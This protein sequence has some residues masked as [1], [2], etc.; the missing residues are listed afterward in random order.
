MKT[1]WFTFSFQQPSGFLGSV[2]NAFSIPYLILA[3]LF[4]FSF[5]FAGTTEAVH[6]TVYIHVKPKTDTLYY[7]PTE[8]DSV[9]PMSK[10][11]NYTR[12]P[13]YLHLDFIS[14]IASFATSAPVIN[15]SLEKS[16][17]KK[18]SLMLLTS[19]IKLT[20]SENGHGNSFSDYYYSGDIQQFSFGLAYRHYNDNTIL[21]GFWEFGAQALYRKMNYTNIPDRQ[22]KIDYPDDNGSDSGMQLYIHKGWQ[23]RSR[24]AGRI[25]F[26][27]EIGAAYNIVPQSNPIDEIMYM[28]NGWQL[29]LKYSVGIGL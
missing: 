28:T 21:C 8:P 16:F 5:S 6:D 27:F 13:F 19:Y 10:D 14:A 23:N 15:I 22:W 26:G 25:G 7:T 18:N 4:L 12:Y 11:T 1:S 24:F 2:K 17:S 20:P 9:I 29:D 3:S